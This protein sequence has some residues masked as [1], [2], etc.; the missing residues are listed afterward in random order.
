ML[1]I[2]FIRDNKEIVKDGINGFLA[3]SKKEW[4]EKLSLL[5][6]NPA[7]RKRMGLAGRQTVEGKFSVKANAP[8]YLDII[9]K[10]YGL[11]DR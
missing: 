1:D 2:K 9:N 3:S 10:V 4:V 11:N 8:K 5:I 6:D 7:L